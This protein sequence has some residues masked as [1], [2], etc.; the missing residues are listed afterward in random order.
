MTLP[1]TLLILLALL[2]SNKGLLL[3]GPWAA[4]ATRLLSKLVYPSLRSEAWGL[5]RREATSWTHRPFATLWPAQ[6]CLLPA[7]LWTPLY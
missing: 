1:S 4:P 7:S 3:G 5:C 2:L 6:P